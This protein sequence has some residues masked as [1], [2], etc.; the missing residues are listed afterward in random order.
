MALWEV[1]MSKVIAV[2]AF[3]V[4]DAVTGEQ[5]NDGRT[6][7]AHFGFDPN[8]CKVS[9]DDNNILSVTQEG[10]K[11]RLLCPPQIWRSV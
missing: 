9:V 11:M 2:D 6:E 7:V 3:I 8:K 10:L 1:R 5:C 4:V